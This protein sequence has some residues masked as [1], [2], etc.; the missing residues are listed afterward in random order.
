MRAWQSARADL[1]S[2]G[3]E[4]VETDFPVVSNYESDRPGAPTIATRGSSPPPTSIGRSMTSRRGDGMI[5]SPR[6]AT[7]ISTPSPRWTEP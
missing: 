1:E 3:A 6:T 5:S 2:A 7:P 4:V